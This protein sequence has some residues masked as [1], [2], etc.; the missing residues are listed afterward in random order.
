MITASN[1]KFFVWGVVLSVLLV[2]GCLFLVTQDLMDIKP[3]GLIKIIP[4]TVTIELILYWV[5]N[6][7]GWKW[8]RFHSWLVVTPNLS[9]DWEGIIHYKWGQ[10]EGDRNTKVSIKQDFNR[11][12][13]ILKTDESIS[14]SILAKF[15][16]DENKC[17]Y[18]LYYTYV[19]EPTITIQD[20]SSIHYGTTRFHFDLANTSVLKGEYWTSRDTKGTIEI[21]K[22]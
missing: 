15:D 5:F 20:R 12:I 14:R 7:W 16:I 18:D 17:I 22:I 6:K 1:K 21:H 4:S 9:G 8:R 19:N 2:Y 10:K 13:V 3:L 11:I